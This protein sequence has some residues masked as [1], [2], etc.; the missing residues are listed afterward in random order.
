MFAIMQNTNNFCPCFPVIFV[1]ANIFG[2]TEKTV[3][4]TA[5]FQ[6]KQFYRLFV[7]HRCWAA[8]CQ[9]HSSVSVSPLSSALQVHATISDFDVKG[10]LLVSCGFQE[11]LYE[12][13]QWEPDPLVKVFDLR[14]P[15]R[16]LTALQ[17]MLLPYL[18]KFHP[19]F[20]SSLAAVGQNGTLQFLDVN[21]AQAEGDLYQ[22]QMSFENVT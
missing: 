7:K 1:F 8:I 20:P 16:E 3:L 17:P 13:G 4:F 2:G 11:S 14:M 22:V 21:T 18:V 6:R 19:L 12:E 10:V 5:L 9:M 15:V